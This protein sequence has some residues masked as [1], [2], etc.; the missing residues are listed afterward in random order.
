MHRH[1]W[2]LLRSFIES[3]PLDIPDPIL[4]Q[5]GLSRGVDSRERTVLKFSKSMEEC[6]RYTFSSPPFKKT[7][8][9][10]VAR[11]LPEVQLTPK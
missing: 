1:R 4:G 7:L 10:F 6:S 2:V 11:H 5:E 8:A 3:G 9:D